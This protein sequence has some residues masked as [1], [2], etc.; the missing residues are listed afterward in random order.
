MKYILQN[1]VLINQNDRDR[2]LITKA[3]QAA[4]IKTN[5][6]GFDSWYAFTTYLEHSG[7]SFPHIFLIDMDLPGDGHTALQHI[8]GNPE[9]AHIVVAV[10]GTGR[11]DKE[12]EQLFMEG[13]NIYINKPRSYKRL[14]KILRHA[15]TIN[16]HY[17]TSALNRENFLLKL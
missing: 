8:R 4:N 17:Y 16:L 3:I 2:T 11:S 6:S 9:Y 10:Y 5:L 7:D 15:L 1:I 12:I 13:A 14:Y